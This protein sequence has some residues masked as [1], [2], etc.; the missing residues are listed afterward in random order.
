[1]SFTKAVPFIVNC[2]SDPEPLQSLLNSV[3]FGTSIFVP[4]FK[5]IC[6]KPCIITGGS[7]AEGFEQLVAE[8]VIGKT[9]TAIVGIVKTVSNLYFFMR[10]FIIYYKINLLKIKELI[11]KAWGL[12]LSEAGFPDPPKY[13]YF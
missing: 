2:V 3:A 5:V 7:G 13:P 11:S 1:V 4:L 8:M 6:P 9:P 10:I 12:E